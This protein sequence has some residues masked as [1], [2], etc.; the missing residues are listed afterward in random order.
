MAST[1]YRGENDDRTFSLLTDLGT[2]KKL[3]TA[4]SS[5]SIPG[6]S[7]TQESSSSA[8]ATETGGTGGGGDDKKTPVGAI[9]GGVVG[10]VG[11]IA[12]VGLGLF[13]FLRKKKA[14]KAAGTTD[15]NTVPPP[16]NAPPMQ[17]QQPGTGPGGYNAVPQNQQTYY[18]PKH[19][20]PS[21]GTQYVQPNS[22]VPG[23]FFPVQG[24]S[25]DPSMH[26][27]SPTVTDPRM[28]VAATSPS[29]SYG[30]YT[31]PAGQQTPQHTGYQQQQQPGFQPQQ[32]VIHEAP[33]NNVDSHRGQMHEL[34]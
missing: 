14:K 22:A 23:G 3:S 8:S 2:D 9:V 34:A 16:Y 10:G 31:T 1:T 15:P 25:S 11:A 6:A 13:F 32:Q 17:Q 20:Y 26:P 7:L 33:D 19:P 5:I 18:D 27:S 12:L 28:S 21:P 29:P 30:G 24:Q 4:T